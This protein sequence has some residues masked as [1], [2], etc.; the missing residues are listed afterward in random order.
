MGL[1]ADTV[2][3]AIGV[4]SQRLTLRD[5]LMTTTL[6]MMMSELSPE[7][8]EWIK[9]RTEKLIKDESALIDREDSTGLNCREFE[10]AKSDIVLK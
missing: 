9:A 2:A 10:R 7:R 6:E 3:A 5:S 4:T 8:Q 1:P